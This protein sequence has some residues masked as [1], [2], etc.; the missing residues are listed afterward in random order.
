MT[1]NVWLIAMS[2]GVLLIGVAL[3]SRSVGAQEQ[4][5]PIADE[6]NEMRG[7]ISAV[8]QNGRSAIVGEIRAFA[9]GGE[10]NTPR[11]LQLRKLG[12]LE[13]K[14]QNLNVLQYPELFKV[15]EDTWGGAKGVSFNA[16]DL[17]GIFLRGWNHGQSKAN[18]DP[19]VAERAA[20][21]PNGSGK[22]DRVGSGQPDALQ[23]H[24]HNLD[25]YNYRQ[26]AA[27]GS[28]YGGLFAGAPTP[29]G[30]TGIVGGNAKSETRPRN[31]YV[32]YCIYV[33]RPVL[34]TTP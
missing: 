18:G 26:I 17:R 16:P 30:T 34:A 12:W 22:A 7:E 3:F 31:V 15:I 2:I 32:M 8:Q 10:N 13:C 24:Q 4:R 28:A 19:D 9:F 23:D 27:P 25:G 29:F 1:K 6:I 20:T 5:K 21:G 14:G 11:M 33:G